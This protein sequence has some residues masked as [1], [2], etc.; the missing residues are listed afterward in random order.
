MSTMQDLAQSISF[1]VAA[2][3]KVLKESN[4]VEPTVGHQEAEFPQLN[5]E[6]ESVRNELLSAISQLERIVVGPFQYLVDLTHQVCRPASTEALKPDQTKTF[7][8]GIL[9]TLTH[10]NIPRLVPAKES[11]SYLQLS[12]LSG[13]REDIL[14]HYIREVICT[15]GFLAEDSA[16]NV[17]HS[18]ASL[19]W[20]VNTDLADTH[21]FDVDHKFPAAVAEAEA[22]AQDPQGTNGLICGYSQAFKATSDGYEPFYK[23]VMRS[24]EQGRKFS[25]M[26]RM[27]STRGGVKEILKLYDWSTMHGKTLVDVCIARADE[28]CAD[29]G[30]GGRLDRSHCRCDC[31][32]S[33]RDQN[34]GA[35]FA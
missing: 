7:D 35:R 34:R 3:S 11:I 33:P 10:F 26:M 22:R 2:L 12:K 30:P 32:S 21:E 16:G 8:V 13:L 20:H 25:N 1:N 14:R 15:M 18:A 28:N 27:A 19:V 4:L 9:R 29:T 23:H 31:R 24:P 5:K 17:C 6:G